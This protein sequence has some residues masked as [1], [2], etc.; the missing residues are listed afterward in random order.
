M[1]DD[2]RYSPG[3]LIT[4]AMTRAS[5]DDSCAIFEDY[6]RDATFIEYAPKP[7]DE[8]LIVLDFGEGKRKSQLGKIAH[9]AALCNRHHPECPGCHATDAL[10]G[11]EIPTKHRSMYADQVTHYSNVIMME[12][13]YNCPQ[14]HDGYSELCCPVCGYREGRWSHKRLDEGDE[15]ARPR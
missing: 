6:Q 7:W 15:E 8:T 3:D 1:S 14:H 5:F 9:R 2:I 10:I 12:Y 4:V 13:S 11:A